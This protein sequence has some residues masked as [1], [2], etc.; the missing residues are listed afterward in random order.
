MAKQETDIA[1]Q[2]MLDLAPLGVRLFKNS[3]GLF[4]TLDVVEKI[5]SAF[6]MGGWQSVLK[7]ISSGG[8]R[9]IRAGLSPNGS[10]DLIGF[11]VIEITPDMVGKKIPV[12]TAIE[13][14]TAN[15]KATPEQ[16]NYIQAV[17]RYNGFAGVARNTQDAKKITNK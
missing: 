1:H 11:T 8:L 3:R 9:K 17:R 7:T 6:K 5:K 2:I 15:G 14:K 13:T 10:S 12:F 4:Y 16:D